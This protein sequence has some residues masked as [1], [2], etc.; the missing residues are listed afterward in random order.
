MTK[1]RVFSHHEARAFYDRFGTRLEPPRFYEDPAIEA[2]LAHADFEH[3]GAVVE[4]GCGTG[5]LAERLL[6][7]RLPQG[8]TYA[9]FD[10]SDAMVHETR[11]HLA[12]WKDRA[13]VHLTD[14]SSTLPLEDG[15]CDRFVATYVLDLLSELDIRATLGEARRLLAPGG[16]L[17]LASLTF[18]TTRRSRAVCRAWSAIHSVSPRLVGGCRPLRLQGFTGADWQIL[19]RE[20]VC[21]FGICMEVLIAS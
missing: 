21:T 13:Q 2:L 20:V 16:R 5:R 4:L 11:A 12:P 7:E 9:G 19:H 1:E 18:G 3:A 6:R 15:A 10:L 14:G 17:C 8:A